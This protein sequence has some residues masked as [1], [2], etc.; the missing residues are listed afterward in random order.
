MIFRRTLLGKMLCFKFQSFNPLG[1]GLQ[2][3]ST[4]TVYTYGDGRR[5]RRTR[6]LAQLQTGFP[7]DLG[8]VIDAPTLSDDFGSVAVAASASLDLGAI[9]VPVSSSRSPRNCLLGS[10]VDLGLTTGAVTVSDDFG[11]T[12]DA[13]V[14]VIDLGTV[15]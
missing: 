10:P 13:V 2:D 7:L 14:D 5:P 9:V 11:S 4:C 3:L 1:G 12:N 15:P 6:I 8:Q